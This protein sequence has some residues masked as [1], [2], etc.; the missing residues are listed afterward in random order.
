[1]DFHSFRSV[2]KTAWIILYCRRLY[3]Y[4]QLVTNDKI[5]E[6]TVT[7]L[8]EKNVVLDNTDLFCYPDIAYISPHPH[9]HTPVSLLH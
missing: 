3:R 8:R 2:G 4:P 6:D 1:M 5:S 9:V 7:Y